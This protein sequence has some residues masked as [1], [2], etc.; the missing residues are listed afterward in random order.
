MVCERTD[1]AVDHAC[2]THD[3][4]DPTIDDG[5]DI[6]I[7][8]VDGRTT[9]ECGKSLACVT[10]E[11]EYGSFIGNRTMIIKTHMEF[12]FFKTGPQELVTYTLYPHLHGRKVEGKERHRY[13][14]IQKLIIHELPHLLGAPDTH[15][16]DYVDNPDDHED[17]LMHFQP[18]DWN[19]PLKTCPDD[20]S[21]YCLDEEFTDGDSEIVGGIYADG[22]DSNN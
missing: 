17:E 10:D 3:T 15:N 2:P 14:Y 9:T 20:S 8:V 21:M 6:T 11:G 22:D 4:D 1:D 16:A 18:S 7:K 19:D 12:Q 13:F 5:H